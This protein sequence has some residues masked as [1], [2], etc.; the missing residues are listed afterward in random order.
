MK[1]E[2]F[3]FKQFTIYQDLC[4]MKVGTDGVLLGSWCVLPEDGNILDIGTGT[5]L[6]ALM[7]A[8]RSCHAHVTGIDIDGMA[9]E[10]ARMNADASPWKQRL[11]FV[12][13]DATSY[14]TEI[15]YEA[16]VCNPPFFTNSLQGPDRRRNLAR[17][18][19]SLPFIALTGKAAS[20]LSE[21]GVFSVILPATQCDTFIQMCWE[22]GLN[23]HKKCFV[24]SN[25]RHP[26]KR[27]ML[28]F[29]KGNTAYPQEEKLYITNEKGEQSAEYKTLTRDF[30]IDR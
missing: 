26:A 11:Y 28:A 15:R 21:N 29:K 10:Q 24:Y 8:Q 20:L 1:K 5:G 22:Q 25:S 14:N 2:Y 6:I 4:A 17:H 16:I 7:A 13:A 23:L 18:T 9:I 19:D 3:Q 12:Q 27:V 30:Y